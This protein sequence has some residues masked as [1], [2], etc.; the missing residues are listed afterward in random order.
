MKASVA[1]LACV[2]C[3]CLSAPAVAVAGTGDVA[4]TRAYLRASYAY[5]R[6]VNREA[7]RGEAAV[8]A[9]ANQI[10]GEC[11]S[12]L[13]YAPRD[14]AF[15][16]VGEEIGATLTTLYWVGA[17]T[18]RAPTLRLVSEITDLR[19]SDRRL[20]RLV[21]AEAAEERASTTIALPDVCADIAG[22]KG[23]AYAT[24]PP[25]A[26]R[27]L[28]RMRVIESLSFVGFTEESREAIILRL[29]RRYEGSSEQADARRL[30]R[31]E[32]RVGARAEATEVAAQTKL[33]AALGVSIL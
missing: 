12:T 13:T 5:E 6:S 26:M 32:V 1:T 21:H 19:W 16:E 25:E 23:T 11:P 20:T 28:A 8:N 22:W 29:L 10:A 33:A 7:A 3:V 31:L 30:D 15:G 24:L 9:R 2:A 14:E 17:P 27:F 18:L 4:A